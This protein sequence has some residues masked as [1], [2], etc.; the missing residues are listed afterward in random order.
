M[1]LE[2]IHKRKNRRGDVPVT[3]L[4]LGVFMVCTLAMLSFINSDRNVEKSFTGIELVEDANIKIEKYN[5][6]NFYNEEIGRKI[7][8]KFGLNW[9]EE[10]VVF[11]VEFNPR[12]TRNP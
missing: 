4:V 7:V 2:K 5:L 6:D 1:K 12:R 8:P 11:S 10:K 3:I 9:I